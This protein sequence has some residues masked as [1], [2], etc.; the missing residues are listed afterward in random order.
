M[1]TTRRT[2]FTDAAKLKMLETSDIVLTP[3]RP[4]RQLIQVSHIIQR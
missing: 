4:S 3:M 2:T 1:A